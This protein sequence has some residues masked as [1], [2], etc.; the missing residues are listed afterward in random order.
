MMTAAWA[1][2]FEHFPVLSPL[3]DSL[4]DSHRLSELTKHTV[5]KC[6]NNVQ[7]LSCILLKY[8]HIAHD[9]A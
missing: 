6:L 4:P 7:S 1:L 2:T 3:S 8:V 9:T 5:K